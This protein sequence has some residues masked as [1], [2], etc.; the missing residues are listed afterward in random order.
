MARSLRI[1]AVMCG[2][3]VALLTPPAAAE[4]TLAVDIGKKATLLDGGHA[5]DVQVTVTCPAGGVVVVVEAFV[6]V[7]QE[8]NESQFAF[9][10]P[11]CDDAP[12]NFT[13]RAQAMDFVFHRGKAR[14]SGYL[15]LESGETTSPTRVVK[16]R[17]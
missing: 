8:D 13:V 5:V 14:A 2:V 9:L 1:L 3:L 17:D 12:H 15:L 10:Q 7:T 11:I 6:Y 16:L 4:A